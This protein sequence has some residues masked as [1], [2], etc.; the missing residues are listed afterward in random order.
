MKSAVV[1]NLFVRIMRLAKSVASEQCYRE[2]RPVSGTNSWMF[3][4]KIMP[5]IGAAYRFI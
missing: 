1:I 2:W 4:K 3:V 5:P